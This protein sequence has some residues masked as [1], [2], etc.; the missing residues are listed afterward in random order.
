[1]QRWAAA[2]ILMYPL[3]V[4]YALI[5][6]VHS[7][8][9]TVPVGAALMV[10]SGLWLLFGTVRPLSATGEGGVRAVSTHA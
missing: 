5:I 10:I 7:T 2:P 9:P 3:G 1:M 6:N 8:P 4:V